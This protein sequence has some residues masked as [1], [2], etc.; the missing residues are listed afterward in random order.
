MNRKGRNLIAGPGCRKKVWYTRPY[1]HSRLKR[2]E[3]LIALGSHQGGSYFCGAWS[4]GA[5]R[6]QTAACINYT[7][8]VTSLCMFTHL[9]PSHLPDTIIFDQVR[10]LQS[11]FPLKFGPAKIKKNESFFFSFQNLMW[12]N[13]NQKYNI[14]KFCIQHSQMYT[15]FRITTDKLSLSYTS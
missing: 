13:K 4:E 11:Y 9:T 6:T 2:M 1:F 5:A 10:F 3:P 8:I 12:F 7:K 14:T 15:G